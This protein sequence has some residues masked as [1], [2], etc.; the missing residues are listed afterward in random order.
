MTATPFVPAARLA[1]VFVSL[2]LATDATLLAQ[3]ARSSSPQVSWEKRCLSDAGTVR[4]CLVPQ[5]AVKARPNIQIDA[6]CHW[7]KVDEKEKRK[8]YRRSANGRP[9]Q[10]TFQVINLC[11]KPVTVRFDLEVA[12]EGDLRFLT[13][14]CEKSDKALELVQR[15]GR[16]QRPA[17]TYLEIPL[18]PIAVGDQKSVTC[19]TLPYEGKFFGKS[20]R[21]TFQLAATAYGDA[22]FKDP[23]F[24]DPEV[25]LEKA[26]HP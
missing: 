20:L 18:G 3:S 19:E 23:I 6:E 1:L 15:E 9:R 26:G 4:A 16:P 12:V 13:P 24:F 14:H 17:R 25:V 7:L 2:A 22:E 5:P 8:Q 10:F 21:R 11:P